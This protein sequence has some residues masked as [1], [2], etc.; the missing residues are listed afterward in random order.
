MIVGLL[1]IWGDTSYTQ[2]C[3]I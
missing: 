2:K 3:K 1:E